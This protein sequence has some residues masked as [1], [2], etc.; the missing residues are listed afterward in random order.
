MEAINVLRWIDRVHDLGAVETLR[1][2]QL[3][4]DAV[5]GVVAIEAVD[6]T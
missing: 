2:R 4:Q 3:Q 1:Q 5:H 6:E